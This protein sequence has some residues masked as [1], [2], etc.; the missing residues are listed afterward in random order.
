[1]ILLY[2]IRCIV[3]A[4]IVM[5]IISGCT[6]KIVSSDVSLN[7]E[8]GGFADNREREYYYVFTEATKHALLNSFKQA[9][10]LYDEILKV[11]EES[12]AVYFQIS[13]ILMRTGN[14]EQA[15]E[16][17]KRAVEYDNNNVW[18]LLHM[19][20]LYQYNGKLDSTIYYY[21]I[22]SDK[23]PERVRYKYNLAIFYREK[24]KLNESLG[25]LNDIE[26]EVGFTREIAYAKNDIYYRM[27]DTAAAVETLEKLYKMFPDDIEVMGLMAESYAE[28]GMAD[29][30]ESIYKELLSIEPGH[31]NGIL[32]YAGFLMDLGRYDEAEEYYVLALEHDEISYERKINTLIEIINRGL[33][34]DKKVSVTENLIRMMVWQDSVYLRSKALYADFLLREERYEEAYG[35][36]KNFLEKDKSMEIAWEQMLYVTNILEK[37]EELADYSEMA[38]EKYPDKGNFYFYSAIGNMQLENYKKVIEIMDEGIVYVKDNRMMIQ[39]Y[40]MYAEAFRGLRQHNRSDEYF[41]KIIALDN[42]N[43]V[44]RNNYA[45]Y[46][47]VR[48][49]KLKR[50]EELSRL[51]IKAEPENTTY[52]DTYGWILFKMG[53][54]KEAEKYLELAIKYGGSINPEILDHYGDILYELDKCKRAVEYW[55]KVKDIDENEKERMDNKIRNCMKEM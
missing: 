41:E 31:D 34:D 7:E 26:N 50:A 39:Y 18:Y 32:S 47:S 37:Y 29:K 11:R 13:N 44:I 48:E 25:I 52:L 2:I 5:F 10:S 15:L 17:G 30:A 36:L 12:P 46:L 28:F 8:N 40:N 27:N 51:T 45:Y 16:Y 1:M 35:Q 21:E 24:G 19:A 55:K 6:R 22:I 53:K 20:N 23:F 9:L 42:D 4:F 38:I 3:G 33:D 54:V 43:L 14:I 49:E